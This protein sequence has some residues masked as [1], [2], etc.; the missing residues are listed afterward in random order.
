MMAVSIFD[1]SGNEIQRTSADELLKTPLKG[2]L[3]FDERSGTVSRH[4]T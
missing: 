3:I 4:D 2:Y 1:I